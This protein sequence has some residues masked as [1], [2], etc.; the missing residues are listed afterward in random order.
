MTY[1]RT[2][3]GNWHLTV[4]AVAFAFLPPVA[5]AMANDLRV[6]DVQLVNGRTPF[7][8]GCSVPGINPGAEAGP[9]LAVDRRRDR[10]VTAWE[11][12]PSEDANSLSVVVGVSDSGGASWDRS[13]V[14]GLSRCTGGKAYY[15]SDPSLAVGRDG[16]AYLG[17][18][19]SSGG[20]TAFQVARSA[21]G[22]RRWDK[23][24]FPDSVGINGWVAA[25]PKLRGAA[26]VVTTSQGSNGQTIGFSQTTD[27][28][29]TWSDPT[30]AY[31]GANV[32]P[33][34]EKLL[35]LSDGTL[36]CLFKQAT[37]AALPDP[38]ELIAP[39]PPDP[40]PFMA[41]R[42]TDRGKTWSA[43]VQFGLRPLR[44]Y[45]HDPEHG[46]PGD[47]DGRVYGPALL[48]AAAGPRGSAYA[49]WADTE[50]P[51]D[52]K[53]LLVRSTDGG[54]TWSPPEP[55]VTLHAE[56]FTPAVA[57]GRDGTVAVTW[58]DF[59]RD[60]PGDAA[61]T[62]D[63]WLAHSHDGGRTWRQAH[64]AGPFDMRQAPEHFGNYL[65]FAQGLAP[66]GRGFGAV[67]AV[68]PP[69]TFDGPSDVLYAPLGLPPRPLAL[70]VEPRQAAAGARVRFTF[71]ATTGSGR[72]RA[73]VGGVRIRFAGHGART[74][75]DGR[76]AIPVTFGAPGRYAA[77]ARKRGYRRAVAYVRAG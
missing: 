53:V 33:A 63:R 38:L 35:A 20:R 6:G 62:T 46:Q 21:N 22:G 18:R 27:G 69:A 23:P 5:T 44:G 14:P 24:I 74:G 72:G 67:F 49:A 36:V 45:P 61:L 2:T 50:S 3:S 75:R 70:S 7:P 9:V 56:A 30:V 26:Y 42:S 47:E 15:A 52:G 65:G 59:R 39:Q 10:L 12:D 68:A 17:T 58:Y 51:T 32:Y 29:Q 73:P 28:G 19:A 16:V 77:T 4:L 60:R 66:V 34:V 71:R 41:I 64:L 76:A 13:L 55:V 8:R 54:A 43:P 57:A 11:Q 37:A 25:D 40:V 1:G 31:G 48:T